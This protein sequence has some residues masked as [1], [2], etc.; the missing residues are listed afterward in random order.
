MQPA[1]ATGSRELRKL[2][3]QDIARLF[4]PKILE[5]GIEYF[6]EGRL[7]RPFVY[8][9]N[10]MAE[11]QGTQPENYHI[12][13]DVR[14]GNVV[15]SCTCPYAFGYCK[16]IAAVLYGWVV[17][18]SAFRDLG[19]SEETLSSLE[20]GQIVEIVMDM[21]RYDPDVTYVINLRLTPA[22]EL[23]E[24][25]RKEM[26]AIFSE[27]YVDYLNVREIVK[28][29]DIFR[30]YASDLSKEKKIDTSL[31][32]LEPVIDAIIGNYTRLDDADG[33]MANF[34]GAVMD[35]F[36]SLLSTIKDEGKLRILL[37]RAL[38]W[39]MDAEWGLESEVLQFL[40]DYPAKLGQDRYM[41]D[42]V[43]LKIAD[44]RRSF[45]STSPK[46]SE[47]H[48]YLD[49]RIRRLNMLKSALRK[50]SPAK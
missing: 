7:Q 10:I 12:N 6:E 21:I 9:S 16:H 25:I 13:I 44:F 40:S 42:A 15:A 50:S 32:V 14:D 11:C 29:L 8:K 43:E 1:G 22:E 39:Y 30:E 17:R 4:S 38:D 33:L 37:T 41:I 2:T 31:A 24:F 49:E 3:E 26:G 48:E 28:K 45:I 47:E 23:P 20:K 35:L 46:Y 34:F 5:R 18:P 27:E 19:K 36:G